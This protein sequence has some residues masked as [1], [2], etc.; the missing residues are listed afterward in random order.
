MMNKE[1]EILHFTETIP[2]TV[3]DHFDRITVKIKE[4]QDMFLEEVDVLIEFI[5]DLCKAGQVF[6]RK[7]FDISTKLY[8]N[9]SKYVKDEKLLPFYQA[10]MNNMLSFNEGVQSTFT[11]FRHNQRIVNNIKKDYK[12]LIISNNN[13]I[14]R[15]NKD[16]IKRTLDD[17][18]LLGEQVELFN[19]NNTYKPGLTHLKYKKEVERY[20]DARMKVHKNLVNNLDNYDIWV[21][22]K[23]YEINLFEGDIKEK[24]KSVLIDMSVEFFETNEIKDKMTRNRSVVEVTTFSGYMNKVEKLVPLNFT[25]FVNIHKYK[26]KFYK[27]YEVKRF[28]DLCK[29]R[30]NTYIFKKILAVEDKIKEK[31]ILFIQLFLSNLYANK[32]RLCDEDFDSLRKLIKDSKIHIYLLYNLILGKGRILLKKPFDSITISDTQ[33]LNFYDTISLLLNYN[34]SPED[35]DYEAAYHLMKFALRV[36]NQ[37]SRSVISKSSEWALFKNNLFWKRLFSFFKGYLQPKQNEDGDII[38]FEEEE[39]TN[40]EKLQGLFSSSNKEPLKN[41]RAVAMAFDN[42]LYLLISCNMPFD[43]IVKR[44]QN[45]VKKGEIELKLA[46]ELV[47]KKLPLFFGTVDLKDK[48]KEKQKKLLD[49]T[50]LDRNA[51]LVMA[52]EFTSP[53]LG[54]QTELLNIVMINKA[55][56]TNKLVLINN[57]LFTISRIKKSLRRGLL[58]YNI[59]ETMRDEEI[60]MDLREDQLD[61][62]IKLDVRRMS[63]KKG[64]KDLLNIEIIL[65]HLSKSKHIKFSYYQGLNN[66][67]KYFYYLLQKNSP[68]V[69]KVLG[70]MLM[71]HFHPFFDDE[72]KK[73]RKLF[74]ALKILTKIN[75]PKLYFYLTDVMKIDLDVVLTSW[76]LTLFTHLSSLKKNKKLMHDIIDIFVSKGWPG[77]CRVVL[78]ALELLSS[79][80]LVSSYDKILLIF[81]AVTKNGFSNIDGKSVNFKTLIRK[82]KEIDNN[83]LDTLTYEYEQNLI[84]F[85]TIFEQTANG[86]H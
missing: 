33:F 30:Y 38:I 86:I 75:L 82:Y 48:I 40:F 13:E 14:E 31:D 35:L 18:D 16:L 10:A 41:K 66:I 71:D 73:L 44:L 51:K 61:P 49:E 20:D 21:Q 11:M 60:T 42:M 58:I 79:Q 24:V 37:D 34:S 27:F 15:R 83:V 46:K 39:P 56:Y 9:T 59:N 50:V 1:P 47:A 43:Y 19:G 29:N 17:I 6:E 80:I 3:V 85:S 2:R 12:D 54:K 65:N 28:N 52:L 67:T 68:L 63:N 4:T 8:K 84:R 70:S 57:F 5:D 78:A 32:E 7:V 25:N 64:S 81:T 22:D 55:T 62:L 36:F 74:F 76:C 53:F 45:L 23:L 72:F 26:H 69:F 77:F